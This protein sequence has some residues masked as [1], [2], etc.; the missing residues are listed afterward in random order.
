MSVDPHDRTATLAPRS[1]TPVAEAQQHEPDPMLP[2]DDPDR[3][4][5]IAEH[6]RGGLGRV[7]RAVDRRL[8]RTV[9]V[10]ELLRRDDS[11]EARFMREAL[12]TARLEHPGIVPVHE[13]GRW[14]NGDPY[15]VMKLVEGRTL[16]EL[17]AR[18]RGLRDRLALLSH[19][20][21]VA[22][23]VGYAHSEGVIHRDIK[24]SNVI[25]GAFGET[26]VI[27]WGLARDSRRDI[28]E[29]NE[30]VLAHGSGV[31]TVSG[32]I[33]GTPAYMAPE[34]ARGELVDPRADVYAI[35]AV[36]YELL[37]GKAPH[38]DDTPEA[39]L[40]RVIAGPPT[41][42]TIAAPHAPSELAD[43]VA[44]AMA[45]DPA[46][47]YANATLLAEDL[48]RFQTGKLV[49]A[50]AYTPWALIRKKLAQHRGVVAVAIASAVAL[51]AVGVESFT[52]VVAERDIAERQRTRADEERHASEQS[53]SELVLVQARTSLQK[54]PTAA[55]AWL[56]LYPIGER[57]VTQVV[58]VIDDAI[59]RGVARYVFRP[60]DWVLDAQFTPDGKTVI[61]AVRDNTLRAYDLQTGSVRELGHLPSISEALAISADGRT[62]FTGGS[63]GEIIEWPIHGGAAKTLAR[64][65]HVRGVHELWRDASGEHLIINPDDHAQMLA[66]DGTL[67]VFGPPLALGVAVAARDLDKR[68][69]LVA[70][71]QVDVVA[72][73]GSLRRVAQTERA[74]K[75][76]ALS[77]LGDL[78]F[79]HDGVT[80]WTVPYAG[81]AL[82][83]LADLPAQV[84]NMAWTDDLKTAA[85]VGKSVDITL[86]DI[87]TRGLR[88]LR[89]HTDAVYMAQFTRDGHALLSASDDG[90]ARVWDLS[91]G[92][93]IELRG[94]D[95]DVYRARLSPDERFAVTA[96]LDGS[97]RVWPIAHDEA[98]IYVEPSSIVE[99]ALSG[100][101][102][103]V[104]TKSTV[105]SWDLTTGER[106]RL[107]EW[108]PSLGEG[109]ASPDGRSVVTNGAAWTLE[110]H[111]ADNAKPIVLKG[112]RALISHTEWSRD[113]SALYSSSYDGTLRKWDV[114]TGTSTTL[115]VGESPVRNFAVAKDGRIAAQIGETA[116]M[117][118][119]D[120]RA[121][122]LG[123]G[124]EWCAMHAQFDEVRD[125]LMIQRCNNGLAMWNGK[126]LVDMQTDGY[127]AVRISVS[128]DG[129][130]VAGALADRTIRVWDARDGH[131][132]ETLRGHEDLVEDVAFSPDGKRLASVSHD[133]TVRVWQLANGRHR[134]LRGHSDETTR[135]AWHG[136]AEL[137]STSTDGTLRVWPVPGTDPPS[138]AQVAARL[139]GATTA[140]IDA[141][142]RATTSGG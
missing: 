138:A 12:I 123:D 117:I 28:A 92:S 132:L 131:M 128:A 74:I 87:A 23:A 41:P 34:Q 95:D 5:Q 30:E 118:W 126:K 114:D 29:P 16:K 78:I 96:S 106:E 40:D 2:V 100:D 110:V 9:A 22:D 56:K 127:E 71:N 7:V 98:K 58:D 55:L 17:M 6:A 57:D 43:L 52:K 26:I 124:A 42:L 21:A 53:K 13:A 119:P 139:D 75:W 116:K 1:D 122:V 61:A 18:H 31:S 103:I 37:A 135:V 63:S 94:H 137:V 66:L 64:I 107:V 76:F 142:N 101:H 47:R 67:T 90:T 36:L 83:K 80:M 121:Q 115:V 62:A 77:P 82:A 99:L 50:H 113:G 70:P 38:A 102:A 49:S 111:G 48:R 89:G 3:Y 54:D 72:P 59:A 86:V 105:S 130:R 129:T 11:H 91:D 46:E 65:E 51:G 88:A 125:R 68:I 108:N 81:G 45:R 79:L 109:V 141:E 25:V 32:K 84:M 24:P 44:K 85:I 10:K 35:G 39:V 33:V 27:D 133:K 60:G 73:D 4:E 93:S 136:D 104:T 140:E 8:G 112:H 134:V 15:Y 19:V 69:A 97:L 20:I 120:G 14:P